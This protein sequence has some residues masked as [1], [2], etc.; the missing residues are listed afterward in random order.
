MC[1]ASALSSVRLP[2]LP[3]SPLAKRSPSPPDLASSSNY[4]IHSG[5]GYA[6]SGLGLRN[7]SLFCRRHR[8]TG[9][10]LPRH[11]AEG[12]RRFLALNE[13]ALCRTSALRAITGRSLNSPPRRLFGMLRHCVNASNAGQAPGGRQHASW[14]TSLRRAT[15]S[16]EPYVITALA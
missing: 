2:D 11:I 15:E 12:R 7:P 13:P 14:S 9:L 6:G 8:F 4:R 3:R 5:H 10:A 1:A 16:S